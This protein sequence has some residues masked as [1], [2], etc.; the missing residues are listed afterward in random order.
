[1]LAELVRQMAVFYD[2]LVVPGAL[3]P[4]RLRNLADHHRVRRLA[5]DAMRPNTWTLFLVGGLVALAVATA[6]TLMIPRIVS[7]RGRSESRVG[8][9]IHQG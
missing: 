3:A 7:G 2:G 9:A 1:M 5:L 4:A 6:L 8:L